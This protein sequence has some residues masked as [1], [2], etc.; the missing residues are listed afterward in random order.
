MQSGEFSYSIIFIGP[1]S[2]KFILAIYIAIFE[3]NNSTYIT[4][5]YKNEKI[6]NNNT[7]Y[8]FIPASVSSSC[9]DGQYYDSSQYFLLFWNNNFSKSVT[10]VQCPTNEFTINQNENCEKCVEGGLCIN[11]NL[12]NQAGLLT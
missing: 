5:N 3:N 11:G 9:N 10:C 6:E 2:K 7:Y 4:A 1:F 12:Y 8:V